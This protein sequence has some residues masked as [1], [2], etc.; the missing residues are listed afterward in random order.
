MSKWLTVGIVINSWSIVAHLIYEAQ[1]HASYCTSV[2]PSPPDGYTKPPVSGWLWCLAW[3]AGCY[4]GHIQIHRGI[5]KEVHS[6]MCLSVTVYY[7]CIMWEHYLMGGWS[8]RG[9]EWIKLERGFAQSR[10]WHWK[11][12]ST[13]WFSMDGDRML[14][15]KKEPWSKKNYLKVSCRENVTNLVCS[16]FCGIGHLNFW[17]F[18][19]YMTCC[20]WKRK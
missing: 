12:D 5:H 6:Q 13:V 14:I 15:Y 19:S 9:V 4:G 17:V 16:D 3:W 10:I 11:S 20:K 1:V 7:F 18:A 2:D 8:S